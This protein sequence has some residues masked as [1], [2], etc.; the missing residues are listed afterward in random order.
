MPR[1]KQVIHEQLSMTHSMTDVMSHV[2]S[3]V[4]SYLMSDICFDRIKLQLLEIFEVTSKQSLYIP[5]LQ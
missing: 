3:H 1:A 2:M 5:I 4:M